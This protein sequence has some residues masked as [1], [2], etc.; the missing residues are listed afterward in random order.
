LKAGAMGDHNPQLVTAPQWAAF[1]KVWSDLSANK[2]D[3][4]PWTS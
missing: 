2:I 1:Q 4:S 3:L